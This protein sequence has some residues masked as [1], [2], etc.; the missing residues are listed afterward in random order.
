MTTAWPILIVG[1][2]LTTVPPVAGHAGEWRTWQAG[3]GLG[4]S[5]IAG[6]SR[7]GTGAIW[8][9]HGDFPAL[10]RMD[11]R[12]FDLIGSPALYNRF[13]TLDGK[14]GWMADR[15]GLH[16]SRNGVW[17]DFPEL[18]FIV[19]SYYDQ[20]RVADLGDS[21]ALLVFPDRLADLS[22]ATRRMDTLPVPPRASAIGRLVLLERA[23]D[24]SIWVIG[25]KGVANLIYSRLDPA[26]LRWKEYPFGDLRITNPTHAVACVGGELFVTGTHKQTARSVALRLVDGKWE[27]IAQQ[28]HGGQSLFAWRDGDGDLWLSDSDVLLRKPAGKRGAEWTVVEPS[29]EVL[30]AKVT[31]V[32]ANPDGSFFVATTRGMAL[33]V[34]SPW[35]AF[36]VTRDSRGKPLDLRQHLTALLEDRQQRMWLRGQHSLFRFDRGTWSEFTFPKEYIVDYNQANS[37][38]ELADGRILIQLEAPPWLGSFDSRTERFSVIPA[39]AGFRPFM[40]CRRAGGG[41]AV[42]LVALSGG[43]DA[44]GVLDKDSISDV[45]SIGARWNLNYPRAMLE[46]GAGELWMAGP[47]GMGRYAQGKFERIEDPPPETIP[48]VP[49]RPRSKSVYGLLAEPDGHVLVGGKEA[50]YRWT[51]KRLELVAD[52]IDTARALIV[53]RSGTFW[54]ASG[55]GLF[56]T[57]ASRR[58]G[59]HHAAGDWIANDTFDGLPSSVAQSILQ[60]SAGRLW[61]GTNKGPAVYLSQTDHDAPTAAIRADQNSSQ[62]APS[63]EFRI[64]FTGKDRWDLTPPELLEFSHR[65]DDGPWTA[66]GRPAMAAFDSLS[67]GKHVFE[68]VAADRQGN[69]GRTPAR[70]EFSVIAPWYR[71]G[72]FLGLLALAIVTI[73]YLVW[74]VFHQV[75]QLSRAWQ[76]AEAANR[77][78]SDF[79]ANMSHEI[80]TPMN[81][82]IGMA[83]LALSSDVPAEQREYMEMVRSSGRVLLTVLNDILDFSKIEARKLELDSVPFGLRQSV[84]EALR[85][86]AV[87]AREK[88]LHLAC[89]VGDDVP[90]GLIG[91][92]GRFRQVILNLIGNAIKFTRQGEVVVSVQ[93]QAQSAGSGTLHVAVRDTGIGIPPEKQQIVFE[94]F[95]QASAS[96]TRSYGG[97]GLGLSISKQLVELMG[98][99]IW[100]ESEVGKGATAHFTAQFQLQPAGQAPGSVPAQSLS[101]SVAVSPLRILL[102]EDHPVNQRLARIILEKQGHS[103]CLAVNGREAVAAAGNGRFDLILMDLQMPEMDGFDA[104]R[105]IRRLEPAGRRTPILALTAHAMAADRQRCLDAGMDGYI[106]KPVRIDE[107]A[108]A[109]AAVCP[110]QTTPTTGVPA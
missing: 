85:P 34:M 45:R 98:G 63:G 4:D 90:D 41:L 64:I 61:V 108:N 54:A 7:D 107:L 95:A 62:A 92:P 94:A 73:S 20:L 21:H 8:A 9:V 67:P 24:G 42:L 51:G 50:L 110:G 89:S 31:Q 5:F 102:V 101:T 39:P 53:D 74:R 80:R 55:S 33:H 97:T 49:P 22:A 106:S 3:Q 26:A 43:S 65:L 60:D 70:L 93:L 6:L 16:H 19:P 13:E 86:I 35:K 100:I 76:Q 1:V 103:V 68:V 84:A 38:E 14:S 2:A 44:L 12:T 37:L 77:A 56:R 82:V 29:N 11:G 47:A 66:F 69:V 105:E 75:R 18:K 91:D 57:L 25:E 23:L 36:G 30:S 59:L 52:R 48:Q 79:L 32:L 58:P 27:I 15:L 87:V 71:T 17:S 10:T 96:T 40:F 88:G 78:K 81:G 109:I 46:N 72:G 99:R 83:E 28:N 104:T